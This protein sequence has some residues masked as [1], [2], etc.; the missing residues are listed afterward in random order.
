MKWQLFAVV[1]LLLLATFFRFHQ[2]DAQSLWHDEGNSLRL[3]ERSVGDLIDAAGRDIHPP[4]YY[5]ILKGWTSVVGTTEFGL[6]S[7][8]AFWG[9]VMVAAT[10][11]LGKR[12]SGLGI[13][14]LIAAVLLAVNP[15]AIYYSQETRMYAQLGA[16]SI[17]SL[18]L[19]L[20]MLDAAN[21][22][23]GYWGWA[24]SLAAC[25]ALGLYTHYTYPFT[26]LAQGVYVL[27]WLSQQRSRITTLPVY[28]GLNVLTLLAFA[29][30]LPTA[31]DQVTTWPSTG[32]QTALIER[33]ERIA[34]ILVYG[35]TINSI[36]TLAFI[37]PGVLLLA[38]LRLRPHLLRQIML[39]G[40]LIVL[41]VGSLLVSG[42]YREANLK[43]LLPAQAAVLVLL[44]LGLLQLRL[45]AKRFPASLRTVMFGGAAVGIAFML[46][47]LSRGID[48]L[49]NDA[50][51]ARSDYR[52][53]VQTIS[54][55]A[56]DNSAVILNAPNQQEVFSYYYHGELPVYPLPR[57]LGGD[58]P[59][60][61]QATAEVVT[62][63]ARVFLVLW[64]QQERDPNAVV[65]STLSD[66]AFAVGR[67]WY[68]DVELVQYAVL[69]PPPAQP[70][71]PLAV[72]FGQHI[73][74][75]GFSLSGEN[76]T[77]GRG[78]A[79]GVALYWETDDTLATRYK[80]SV[81]VLTP[82]GTLADQHDSEPVNGLRP[83]TTW[84]PGERIVD[85]HG[86]VLDPTLPP[87]DYTLNVVVYDSND[88]RQRLAP[89]TG[90]PNAILRLGTLQLIP[91][92]Q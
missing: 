27:W 75:H 71:T 62:S 90:A 46:A 65:Q 5:L 40:L 79:L 57:G 9:V 23:R 44:G 14:G 19:L 21:S 22:K 58:D 28:I 92:R 50:T 13:V 34:T 74:L 80:V 73:T 42:A 29:P 52:G 7:L 88:P 11:A 60:T 10:Y 30:W 68:G 33:V 82:Q 55:T 91:P 39:P 3:A 67:R 54:R 38:S 17:L 15:F 2:L 12:L 4:G 78:D 48:A 61:R 45:I 35:N 72:R 70:Q 53:I 41:S 63:H 20:R 16:L 87:G 24:L 49:Y 85:N 64:G 77:A 84:Q 18:W 43:F 31:Y 32:D 81:Q 83:T 86:L 1:L 69:S 37:V 6:R 59:A 25:N 56:T 36:D 89:D 8:S 51:Y 26:M 76:F 66:N 47:P